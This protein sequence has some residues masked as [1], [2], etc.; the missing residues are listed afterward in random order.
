MPGPGAPPRA[1]MNHA[2]RSSPADADGRLLV[3]QPAGV[4]HHAGR[5]PAR[6]AGPD[7]V[8]E[9]EPVGEAQRRGRECRQQPG[10]SDGSHAARGRHDRRTCQAPYTPHVAKRDPHEVLGVGRDATAT[11]IKAAWRRLARANHPDLTGDDPALSRVATRQMAEIN[12]AYAALTRDAAGRSRGRPGRRARRP[13]TTTAPPK[14]GGPPRPKPTRPVTGRVD[15]SATYRRSQRG[16]P[17]HGAPTDARCPASRRPRRNRSAA[18]RRGPRRRPARS[19]RTG[20]ATSAAGRR[21]RWRRRTSTRSSSAS[22]TATRSGQIASFEPSYIDWLG[23]T[24]TRDPE[25]VAA[26]RVVQADLDRRGIVRRA[27]PVPE[28]VE[29]PGRTA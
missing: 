12:D 6:E 29:R 7:A 2:G 1:G 27:R 26:A 11:E 19:S 28:R 23:G 25:L 5:V 18:S 14:R 20:S 15:M 9:R 22:S 16:R 10:A 3:R 13:S 17:S 4:G 8:R 21:P 24:V